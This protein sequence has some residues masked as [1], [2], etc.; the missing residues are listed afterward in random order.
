MRALTPKLE[1]AVQSRSRRPA[2]KVLAFDPKLDTMSAI[3]N[4]TYT[5]TPYDLT[6]YCTDIT[7]SPA[8]LQFKLADANL[9]F[10]PDYGAQRN[11]LVDKAIIR[12]V[13]GEEGL[14]ESL[15]IMTF[16]GYVQ[17]QVGWR[18]ER[19]SQTLVAQISVYSREN[20]PPWKLRS[21]TTRSYSVGT[22]IGVML[23]DLCTELMGMS[24]EELRFPL[25]LG[26]QFRHQ[27]NQIVQMAPWEAVLAILQAVSRVPFF[28]GDGRLT[29]YSKDLSLPEARKL[30]DW[31]GILNY[32]IPENNQP[33]I[34]RVNII[35]LDS[36]LSKVPGPCQKLGTA[37]ITAGFFMPKFE[38]DTWW[39][40]D[41]KQRAE[42]TFMLTKQSC[43]TRV[44]RLVPIKWAEESY[45]E[46]DEY[47]GKITVDVPIYSDLIFAFE[48]LQYAVTTLINYDDVITFGMF[49]EEGITIPIGRLRSAMSLIIILA[50]MMCIGTGSYEVWGTPYDYCYQEQKSIA[51]QCNLNYW[52]EN[53]KDIKNDF[54]GSYDQA[55]AVALTE[56]IWEKSASLPRK[57]VIRDD[58]ALEIGDTIRLPDGLKFC[59]TDMSKQLVRGEVPLLSL[60]GFK[61]MRA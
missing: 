18:L 57:L 55:D 42:G 12:L 35:F 49:A 20:N 31:K 34:N 26:L 45:Q 22:E 53:P 47:H 30:K 14:D 24:E 5:Q 36:A 1:E 7:W 39:S 54:L 9:L 17:G 15:W 43:V 16:T 27:S 28:D 38:L 11:Y 2:Y 41:R 50:T 10:H 8:R 61:V 25:V 6:P 40:D 4:G 48:L 33:A 46:I 59:I 51:I 32:E 19:R 29:S 60:D 58:P 56:L 37:Q 21:I 3:V 13:E 44:G 23:M 52:E